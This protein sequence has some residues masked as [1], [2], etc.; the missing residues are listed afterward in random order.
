MAVA[1]NGCLEFNRSRKLLGHQESYPYTIELSM[2]Q[3]PVGGKKKR[4]ECDIV[5]RLQV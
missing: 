1:Q 4:R 2:V 3:Y 5:K